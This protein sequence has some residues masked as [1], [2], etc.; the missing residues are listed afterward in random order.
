MAQLPYDPKNDNG[1]K[2]SFQLFS[3]LSS[4]PLAFFDVCFM[5]SYHSL[6]APESKKALAV[7]DEVTTSPFLL[8][9]LTE[10]LL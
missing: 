3:Y 6:L 4:Y 10:S 5:D 9:S 8:P 1:M 2:H 7:F